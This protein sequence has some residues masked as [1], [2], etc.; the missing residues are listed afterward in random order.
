MLPEAD[1]QTIGLPQIIRMETKRL[2]LMMWTIGISA[3]I[4]VGMLTMRGED[5]ESTETNFPMI[6]DHL[7][8]TLV[9]DTDL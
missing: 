3:L 4:V 1:A 2:R 8:M 6:Q 7:K 5:R 9:I